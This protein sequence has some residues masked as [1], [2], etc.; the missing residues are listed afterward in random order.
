MCIVQCLIFLCS[1]QNLEVHRLFPSVYKEPVVQFC[2]SHEKPY[3]QLRCLNKI[4]F[5]FSFPSLGSFR[6]YS[7]ENCY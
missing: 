6:I 4:K 3:G 7:K 1:L 5:K 2:F